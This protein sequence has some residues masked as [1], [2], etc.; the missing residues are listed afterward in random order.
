L[1][2]P[3]PSSRAELR[4]EGYFPIRWSALLQEMAPTP[5][6]DFVVV[7]GF[8][9]PDDHAKLH[10]IAAANASFLNEQDSERLTA[11]VT[12]ALKS[13]GG[14]RNLV[15]R[16][17]GR[18]AD[19]RSLL[20]D[21]LEAAVRDG[22]GDGDVKPKGAR[23]VVLVGFGA[24][25]GA[26]CDDF[27]SDERLKS[28]ARHFAARGG[29]VLIQGRGGAIDLIS[30]HWFQKT[31][32]S[33]L[34]RGA[35]RSWRYNSDS[36]WGGGYFARFSDAASAQ[37]EPSLRKEVRFGVVYEVERVK[38][39]D[40]VYLSVP[41]KDEEDEEDEE[42]EKPVIGYRN[43][44][45]G[46]TCAVAFGAFGGGHVG[47]IGAG[48]DHQETT[49]RV[50]QGLCEA[51]PGV[52]TPD[53]LKRLKKSGMKGFDLR[54]VA[55]GGGGQVAVEPSMTKFALFAV[56]S[57]VVSIILVVYLAMLVIRSNM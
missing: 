3:D 7:G 19:D 33:G 50:I 2:S 18:N 38:P 17:D 51:A 4:V 45:L 10:P 16:T 54:E 47:C 27:L 11:S 36:A 13:A 5:T 1:R 52:G 28:C 6:Y 40:A 14:G 8:H 9:A 35:E 41:H 29:V 34:K 48:D 21:V 26:Q 39:V 20:A 15:R 56:F 55:T 12:S 24:G 30:R 49:L 37:G 31:W 32:T 57:A 42:D 22:G 23:A 46:A 25:G 43:V 44:T 53:A